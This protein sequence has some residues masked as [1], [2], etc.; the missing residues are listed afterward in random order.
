MPR[1]MLGRAKMRRHCRRWRGWLAR[2]GTAHI[3]KRIE[4]HPAPHKRNGFAVP[5]R[6][7]TGTYRFHLGTLLPYWETR[8]RNP[9]SHLTTGTC[10]LRRYHSF[11]DRRG[12]KRAHCAAGDRRRTGPACRRTLAQQR[13]AARGADSRGG[14]TVADDQRSAD[15]ARQAA[16]HAC[17]PIGRV[18]RG[19]DRSTGCRRTRISIRGV[20]IHGFAKLSAPA[21]AG[22]RS[23]RVDGPQ[24]LVSMSLCRCLC[25]GPLTL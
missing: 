7:A 14:A 24:Q 10:R 21:K 1:R 3:A 18:R 19:G 25:E 9:P 17:C 20:M 16:P 12:S 2:H 13:P 15:A 5:I 23:S 6:R 11:L 4:C 22:R 8:A